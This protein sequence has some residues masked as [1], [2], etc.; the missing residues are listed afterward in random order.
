MTAI[1]AIMSDS[2]SPGDGIRSLEDAFI[3][4]TLEEEI[5]DLTER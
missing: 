1:A 5:I 4:L 2:G 3:D